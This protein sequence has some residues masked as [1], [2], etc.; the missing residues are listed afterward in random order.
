ME[1]WGKV[2]A[3]GILTVAAFISEERPPHSLINILHFRAHI[4]QLY[5]CGEADGPAGHKHDSEC[6]MNRYC[7]V[8]NSHSKSAMCIN[9]SNGSKWHMNN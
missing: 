5:A 8:G 7:S 4:A 1:N 6:S 9:S 3:I 2:C